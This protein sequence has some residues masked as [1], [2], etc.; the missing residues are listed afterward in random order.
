M[1]AHAG[2]PLLA[3]TRNVTSTLCRAVMMAV[4]ERAV[5]VMAALERRV[6]CLDDF[7]GQS[8]SDWTERANPTASGGEW[9]LRLPYFAIHHQK[10]SRMCFIF[11]GKGTA[12]RTMLP[13]QRT[14]RVLV[15]AGLRACA[16]SLSR[17]YW[18]LFFIFFKN[19]F[20]KIPV[21]FGDTIRTL[22]SQC[23][24]L[25]HLVMNNHRWHLC[26]KVCKKQ[27]SGSPLLASH[28]CLIDAGAGGH[29][30]GVWR[31]CYHVKWAK[32]LVSPF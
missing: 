3:G 24:Q 23:I 8:W 32:A 7:V 1:R 10:V 4:R 15:P 16:L 22:F 17:S 11:R 31:C 30:G 21:S 19:R 29:E 20:M 13:K 6:P 9:A 18:T 27:L 25:N 2:L 5:K 28:W 26:K 12:S 14:G